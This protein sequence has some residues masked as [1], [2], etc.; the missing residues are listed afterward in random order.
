MH[1]VATVSPFAFVVD[2]YIESAQ[3]Q[4]ARDMLNCCRRRCRIFSH[5]P[6][7]A[8]GA[9]AHTLNGSISSGSQNKLRLYYMHRL[10]CS[11]GLLLLVYS[12]EFGVS[13][14]YLETAKVPTSWRAI[15]ARRTA[16]ISPE[17][18]LSSTI[19]R[20]WSGCEMVSLNR[21]FWQSRPRTA[22]LWFADYF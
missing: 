1:E 18:L 14:S 9:C 17:K 15:A 3:I 2:I 21:S 5:M 6:H 13:V 16:T 8:R 19:E 11:K 20:E 4:Y 12:P 10:R 22:L 7:G